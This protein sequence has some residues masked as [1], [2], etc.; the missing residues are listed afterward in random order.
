MKLQNILLENS[1]LTPAI[2]TMK[3]GTVIRADH[4]RIVTYPSGN[5]VLVVGIGPGTHTYHSSSVG[6]RGAPLVRK[7]RDFY[8]PDRYEPAEWQDSTGWDNGEDWGDGDV[9]YD[10]HRECY[11]TKKFATILTIRP[12]NI[13][14][15]EWGS[16]RATNALG[17]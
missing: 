16:G 17:T 13:A 1:R 2:I 14:S 8:A 7:L 15:I 4:A 9:T 6:T 3:R 11:T 12:H 5:K 10:A